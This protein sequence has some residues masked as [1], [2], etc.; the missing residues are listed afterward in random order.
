[1]VVELEVVVVVMMR[2]L[3]LLVV[4]EAEGEMTAWSVFIRKRIIHKKL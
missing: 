3:C 2:V 1:M 4:E